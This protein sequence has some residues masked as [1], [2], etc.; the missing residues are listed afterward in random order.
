MDSTSLFNKAL[1]QRLC[2]KGLMRFE[3]VLHPSPLVL[4]ALDTPLGLTDR[5]R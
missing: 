1:R 4:Q 3:S 5:A 2:I